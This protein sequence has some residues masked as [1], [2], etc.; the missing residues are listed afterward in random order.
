MKGSHGIQACRTDA[1]PPSERRRF[2]KERSFERM[3]KREQLGKRCGGKES[4][5][6]RRTDKKVAR[7]T[8]SK[9]RVSP[10]VK[11]QRKGRER[12]IVRR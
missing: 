1:V 9:T 12:L 7:W 11:A 3:Q 4:A 10:K 8:E 2:T 5:D 6:Q